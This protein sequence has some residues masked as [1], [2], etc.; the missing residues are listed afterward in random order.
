MSGQRTAGILPAS[1]VCKR[2]KLAIAAGTWQFQQPAGPTVD[3]VQ[4]LRRAGLS[5]GAIAAAAGLPLSVIAPL[6]WYQTHSNARRFVSP[7]TAAA[8]AAVTIRDAP[9]WAWIPAI[10]TRRRVEA[11]QCMGWSQRAIA[12][13]LGVSVPAVGR[14]KSRPRIQ[15]AKARRIAEIYDAWSMTPGPDRRTRAWAAKEGYA[16]PLAWDETTIDDPD[17]EPCGT[18]ATSTTGTHALDVDPVAV[19]RALAGDQVHLTRA[20]R[21]AAIA[22]TTA[23]GL[24]LEAAAALLRVSPHTI[25]RHRQAA[26]ETAPEP[27]RRSA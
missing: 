8:I 25:L 18:L 20:E 22:A 13:E 12:N 24:S 21:A 15:A 17:A 26:A 11:L 14:V 9:D 5:A 4:A 3:R 7:R 27:A 19:D 2:R 1:M 16:P 23:L 10:G 6:F